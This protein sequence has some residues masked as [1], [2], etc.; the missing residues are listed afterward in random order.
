MSIIIEDGG[1]TGKRAKVDANNRLFVNSIA[2][3]LIDH[4]TDYGERYNINTGNVTLNS[5]TESA[6]LYVKNNEDDDL[7]ITSLVYNIGSATS[8]DNILVDVYRN[9]TSGTIVSGATNV[10]AVS[11]MNYGSNKTL[12]VNA[13]V[14]AQSLTQTGGTISVKSIIREK[15][16]AVVSLGAI[17]LPKGS[18]LAVTVT[19]PTGNTGVLVNIAA[20]CFRYTSE[21][22]GE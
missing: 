5:T 6:L 9:P 4:A 14:G 21:V 3:S 7:V 18:S 17:H 15:T 16:R 13:Y 12:L 19:P 10:T 1:G 2:E 22:A 8:T 11:N 20:S